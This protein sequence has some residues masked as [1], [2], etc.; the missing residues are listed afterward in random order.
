MPKKSRRLRPALPPLEPRLR[1]RYH[2]LVQEQL[3]VS[4]SVAA[5]LNAL[6]G[7]ASSFASTQAAWRFYNNPDVTLPASPNPCWHARARPSPRPAASM[8]WSCMTGPI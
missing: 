6:P 7:A 8:A 3:H 2:Q 1:R 4:Q 5:G